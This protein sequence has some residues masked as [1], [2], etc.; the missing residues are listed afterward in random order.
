MNLIINT[1]KSLPNLLPLKA[2][3]K[4]EVTDAELQLRIQFAADYTDYLMVFG[5]II[6]DGIELTGITKSDYRNVVLVT[7]KEWTLNP[8]VPHSMYVIENTGVDGII[9]WQDTTGTIYQ[10]SPDKKPKKI[11]ESLNNYIISRT[12]L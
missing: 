1:I 8:K 4:K 5:A 10:T 6:A 3:S 7:K 11:A 12:T 9:I 2:V